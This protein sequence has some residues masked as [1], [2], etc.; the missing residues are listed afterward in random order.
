MAVAKLT[1]K[2]QIT[3]PAEIRHRLDLRAGDSVVMELDG[4][5][6]VLRPVHGGHTARMRGLGKSVWTRLGGCEN[7]LEQ[8]RQAW[9]DD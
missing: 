4:E 7:W 1:N 9:D 3:I 2:F 5:Q 8:E 6:A